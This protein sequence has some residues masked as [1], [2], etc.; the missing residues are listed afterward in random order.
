MAEL[1]GL[2]AR[3]EELTALADALGARDLAALEP[4]AELDLLAAYA[5]PESLRQAGSGAAPEHRAWSYAEAALGA[6]VFLPLMLTWYGLTKASSAYGA[7]TGDDP[8]AASRPFLQLWQS[9]FEG[10]LTGAFTFGHVAMSATAA[11]TVLFTLVLVHGVRRATLTRREEA[12]GRCAEDLMARLVPVLT[13]AQLVLNEQRRSSPQRF[14]AELTEAATTLN[15]LGNNAVRAHKQLTSAAGVVSDA[16]EAAERRL[17]GV[18]GAVQPLEAAAARIETAVQDGAARVGGA[19]DDV[20]GAHGDI[21]EAVQGAGDRVEESVTVLAASQRA[22]TTGIE[23]A[24]DVVTRLL[25]SVGEIT[26]STARA[27]AESQQAAREMRAQT[28]ALRSAAERFASLAD[29]LRSV[30]TADRPGEHPVDGPPGD[31]RRAPDGHRAE[32]APR[33][34]DAPRAGTEREPGPVP[35]ALNEAL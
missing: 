15:K 11:I 13:R 6:L 8:K 7:L 32:G 9:G 12:A 29:G 17:A 30:R 10:H 16:V 25:D 22:Y 19:L 18:D 14:T 5:R 3:R 34:E 28:E 1:P 27:V 4:W 21:R 35:S 24:A 2:G 31:G 23:V 33:A 20:R 26:D